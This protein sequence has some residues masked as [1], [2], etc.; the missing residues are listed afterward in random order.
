MVNT[1]VNALKSTMDPKH[2]QVQYLN[3][4]ESSEPEPVFSLDVDIP[5]DIP[6]LGDLHGSI[7]DFSG[8]PTWEYP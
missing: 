4:F 3:W 5:T 1:P 8:H 7:F 2:A 6:M